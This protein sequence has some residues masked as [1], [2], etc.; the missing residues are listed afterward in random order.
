MHRTDY[1]IVSLTETDEPDAVA[2]VSHGPLTQRLG[3]P[4]TYVDIYRLD[5]GAITVGS[6]REQLCVP[7][8]GPGTVSTDSQVSVSPPGVAFVPAGR[9][10][11]LASD[12]SMS[13]VIVSA[14]PRY[15]TEGAATVVD[16]SGDAFESPATSDVLT[17][18]LTSELGCTA[19]KV[20][21]RKLQPGQAVPY[22]TEGRQQELFVPV[23]GPGEMRIAGDVYDVAPGTVSRVAP[24]TP[25][26][27]VNVGEEDLTWVMVGAPPTGGPDDWDPGATVL[28]WSGEP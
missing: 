25:R 27:A 18:R 22:H 12:D 26:S 16:A 17:A 23:D 9:S 19:M 2:A 5:G 4:E 13:W 21:L 10:C 24:A 14:S 7:I 6:T 3:C 15:R 8:D 11:T 1:A 20:N 28:E